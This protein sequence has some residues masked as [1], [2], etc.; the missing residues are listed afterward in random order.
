M[1]GQPDAQATVLQL[2]LIL[3]DAKRTHDVRT[4]RALIPDDVSLVTDRG[5][6]LTAADLLTEVGD[7]RVTWLNND[8]EEAQ[9]R[10]YGDCAILTAYLRQ[11]YQIDGRLYERRIRSTDTWVRV[12]G[13]WKYVAGHASPA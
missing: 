1:N 6:F 8:T 11:R 7:A 2:N 5:A 9:V 4:V 13:G 12:E 3:Q 10:V